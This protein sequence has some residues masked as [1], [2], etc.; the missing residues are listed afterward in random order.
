M[1]I[2]DCRKRCRHYNNVNPYGWE[3]CEAHG[4]RCEDVLRE[5][6][7]SKCKIQN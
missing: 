1:T 6:N 7:N 2:E 5:I 4:V 3:Y